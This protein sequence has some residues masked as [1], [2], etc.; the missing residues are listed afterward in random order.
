M[1]RIPSLPFRVIVYTRAANG[2]PTRAEQHNYE[3][4]P[5][6]NAYRDIALRRSNTRKV[7]TCLVIDESTPAHSVEPERRMRAHRT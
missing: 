1:A 7:E 3:T 5:G 6:A 4:L 2:Q